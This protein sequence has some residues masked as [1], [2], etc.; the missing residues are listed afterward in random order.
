M[1]AAA[2]PSVLRARA[3]AA[4]PAG[5]RRSTSGRT[6]GRRDAAVSRRMSGLA[7]RDNE[8]ESVRSALHA[9]GLRFRVTYRI[10]DIPRRTIDIAFTR[11]RVAVFLDGC[12]WHGC[13]AHGTPPRSNSTWWAE[14]IAANQGRDVD[15]THRLE[16]SGWLFLRIGSTNTKD[17]AVIAIEWAGSSPAHISGEVEADDP[18]DC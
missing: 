15:T 3:T 10:P 4:H 8:R 1:T 2:G 16:S 17:D 12:F 6:P 9:R 5:P 18:G 14:K 13:P 7:R 11:A